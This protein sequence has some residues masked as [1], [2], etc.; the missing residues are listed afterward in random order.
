MS[1]PWSARAEPASSGAALGLVTRLEGSGVDP[2]A[3]RQALAHELDLPV[4]RVD[5]ERG[6]S[7]RVEGS[8][9]SAVRIAFSR[10]TAPAIE[11]SLD[12]STV[13]AHATETIA[14]V[15]A[16]LIRDEAGELLAQLRAQAGS[17]APPAPPPQPPPTPAPAATPRAKPAP[18]TAP[19]PEPPEPPR[20]CAPNRLRPVPFGVDFVPG[21]GS[22]SEQG[23]DVERKLSLNVLGGLTGGT[24]GFEAA[25]LFNYDA[26]SVC[27]TQ[28]A[29]V[30]NIVGGPVDGAQ[31]GLGNVATGPVRGTQ[32]SL[33]NVSGG[34]V[35]GA[36]IGLAN[37]SA[38][39]TTGAQIGLANVSA[40]PVHGAMLG[41]VNV[42]ES[43]D[44]P[45]GLVNVMYRGRTQLDMWG[46]DAGLVML[47]IEH[48]GRYFHNIY[49][50]GGTVRHGRFVLAAAYGIGS[51]LVAD[52]RWSLDID[53]LGYGLFVRNP[54][55]NRYEASTIVQLRVPIALQLTPAIALFASPALNVSI[56]KFDDLL[57]DPSL[58]ASTRL[59]HSS[60]ETMVRLWPGFTAGVRFF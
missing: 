29:G 10:D 46:T 11:R 16:N 47:G 58:Y 21:L 27:G 35:R 5:A 30:V 56:A 36:Q 2:E 53:A 17:S 7:L 4:E 23:T 20:G 3:L 12:L 49:G 34:R 26:H 6:P 43:A 51:R 31:L 39:E 44:A 9:L 60:S 24:R 15:A 32:V 41:L 59:T 37:V 54:N 1:V 18:P 33:A 8:T 22:S 38:A 57:A 45:I 40:G 55:L 28:V 50:L 13:G 52:K 42:A 19:Q 25:L 14:L 48:G